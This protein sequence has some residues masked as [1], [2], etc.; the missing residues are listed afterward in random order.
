MTFRAKVVASFDSTV[1]LSEVGGDSVSLAGDN[2]DRS[3]TLELKSDE[4]TF[5][6]NIEST[7]ASLTPVYLVVD[8]RPGE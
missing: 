3:G 8:W 7:D 4:P 2:T 6:V 1:I 5:D